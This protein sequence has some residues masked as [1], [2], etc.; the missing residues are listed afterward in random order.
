LWRLFGLIWIAFGVGPASG[1][2]FGWGGCFVKDLFGLAFIT[3]RSL[4]SLR[5]KLLLVF[6]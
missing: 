6:D 1:G 4:D 3:A 2:G 5:V